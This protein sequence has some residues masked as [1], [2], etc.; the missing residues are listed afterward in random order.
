MIKFADA[1]N[2]VLKTL[3]LC[4]HSEDSQQFFNASEIAR[5]NGQLFGAVVGRAAEKLVAD[6]LLERRF[7]RYDEDD[8][9]AAS[10]YRLTDDGIFK[11]EEQ[12]DDVFE[13]RGA[14]PGELILDGGNAAGH[15]P[16]SDRVVPLDHNSPQ[17]REFKQGLSVLLS[18]V[19]GNNKIGDT[20]EERDRIV[21]SLDAANEL[22][23]SLELKVIQIRVGVI[24][25][26]EDAGN[27]LQKVGRETAWSLLIDLLK[28]LIKEKIG[29]EI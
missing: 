16:A 2:E 25:A 22:W 20:P 26:V 28:R 10:F 11:A 5:R 24:L 15:V 29:I 3:L 4:L 27:A 21:R 14:A 23:G 19:R 1:Q 18:E 7:D 8:D 6:G 17:Y 9:D 12:V 13:I